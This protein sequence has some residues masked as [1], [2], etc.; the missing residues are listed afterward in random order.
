M[1]HYYTW[2]NN[3]NTTTNVTTHSSDIMVDNNSSTITVPEDGATNSTEFSTYR[4][5]S[6]V[7]D[8]YH[9]LNLTMVDSTISIMESEGEKINRTSYC[10]TDLSLLLK[11]LN[12]ENNYD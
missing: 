6:T 1:D 7:I 3:L 10:S 12:I 4:W 8:L 5:C 2:C 9:K 11:C